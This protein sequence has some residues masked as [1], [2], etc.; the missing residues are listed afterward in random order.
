MKIKK[1]RESSDKQL[2]EQAYKT[3]GELGFGLNGEIETVTQRGFTFSTMSIRANIQ[4]AILI[5]EG[6]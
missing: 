3:R 5:H 1:S 6:S 4:T 2:V